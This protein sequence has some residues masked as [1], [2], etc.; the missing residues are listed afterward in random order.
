MTLYVTKRRPRNT[1]RMWISNEYW[2]GNPGDIPICAFVCSGGACIATPGKYWLWVY[3]VYKYIPTHY[4]HISSIAGI[5]FLNFHSK[6]HVKSSCSLSRSS[7]DVPL[8]VVVLWCNITDLEAVQSVLFTTKPIFVFFLTACF[9]ESVRLF[10]GTDR[11]SGRVEVF[12][13]GRWGKI[14]KD[15][16]GLEEATVVCKELS[17]GSPKKSQ[18]SF[19]FGESGLRG[20]TSTC[21]GNVSSISQCAFQENTGGCESA[22]LSCAGK[23]QKIHHL[24]RAAKDM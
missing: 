16:W 15:K 24:T 14:C 9:P 2:I 4:F 18:E 11:C 13:D 3:T 17:C 5:S 20:Y 7:F 22:S 8:F 23:T 10:N 19:N 12:H 1:T 6:I 21:S